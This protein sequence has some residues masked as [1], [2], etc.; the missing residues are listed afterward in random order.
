[1]FLKLP[2]LKKI[3]F[4]FEKVKA[5]K[6]RQ[7]Q[8]LKKKLKQNH[9]VMKKMEEEEMEEETDEEEEAE[10]TDEEEDQNSQ[11]CVWKHFLSFLLLQ[12]PQLGKL[13]LF[14]TQASGEYMPLQHLSCSTQRMENDASDFSVKKFQ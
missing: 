4:L 8:N 12:V 11:F 6:E 14:A 5:K 9:K 2:H 7:K 1:M 3:K 13:S 10:E